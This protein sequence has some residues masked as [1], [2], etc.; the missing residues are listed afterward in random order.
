LLVAL[1]LLFVTNIPFIVLVL[2]FFLVVAIGR[3]SRS[4]Q[5]SWVACR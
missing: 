3:R 4:K 5:R 2:G 1:I